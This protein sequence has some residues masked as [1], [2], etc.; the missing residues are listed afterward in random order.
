MLQAGFA[1]FT[2]ASLVCGVAPSAA[3]LVA[4]R[5][6]QGAGAALVAPSALALLNDA[7]PDGPARG[8]ALAAWTAAAAGGGASGWVLGGVLAG[9]PGWRWVFFANLPIGIAVTLLAG[10]LIRERRAPAGGGLGLPAGVVLTLALGLLGLGLTRAEQAG[11]AAAVVPLLAAGVAGIAFARIER[12]ATRPLL[13]GRLLRSARFAR[14][15]GAALVLTATTTP[16]MFLAILYQH[17]VL[18]RGPLATGIGCAPFNL[19]VIAGSLLGPRALER[20]GERIAMSAGLGV[21]A[22]GALVLA[23][24]AAAGAP[25]GLPVAFV[26]MG[27]GLGCASVAS[28]AAGTAAPEAGDEGVAS[29]VLNAAAQVGTALGLALLVTLAAA[30]AEAAGGGADG[31]IDGLQVAVLAA[32]AIAASAALALSWPPHGLRHARADRPRARRGRR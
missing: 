28:T 18:G 32:A 17:E 27:A 29:G 13:P 16:P 6:V 3:V 2:L 21:I 1:L 19:A 30:R 9:G 25:A 24:A 5:A 15:S 4:A 7:V 23:G 11:P 12:G 20:A 31:L 8:K 10:R 14:G 26:L 22:G